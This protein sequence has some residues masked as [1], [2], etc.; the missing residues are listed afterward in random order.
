MILGIAGHSPSFLLP[1]VNDFCSAPIIANAVPAQ[2][3]ACL[4]FWL[5][6]YQSLI[7]GT[8]ALAG[9]LATV[10]AIRRQIRQADR[11]EERRRAGE[12]EAWRGVLPLALSA[13]CEYAEECVRVQ[14]ALVPGSLG[15]AGMHFNPPQ[16]PNN[17]IE[18][19][20]ENIRLA[21]PHAAK[22]LAELL[23]FF[24]V[25][26]SRLRSLATSDR[27]SD[28]RI[29][30]S[31]FDAGRLYALASSLFSYGRGDNNIRLH[32]IKLDDIASALRVMRIYDGY[33]QSL[34]NLIA[35]RREAEARSA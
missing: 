28:H 30:E 1:I 23:S 18:P 29:D 5:N 17:L 8:L 6:R 24:Q 26:S 27:I 31:L 11:L 34:D 7:A 4:E 2:A 3:L 12:R 19:L 22:R 20:R 14:E 33:R 9:A 25:Q 32:P 15:T 21:D 13:I 16:L 10:E 35:N